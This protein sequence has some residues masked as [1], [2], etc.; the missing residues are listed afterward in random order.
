[1]TRAPTGGASETRAESVVASPLFAFAYIGLMAASVLY[2]YFRIVSLPWFTMHVAYI[3]IIGMACVW[4]FVT[5]R[6]SRLKN[7]FLAIAIY[8]VPYIVMLIQSL[9]IWIFEMDA[10]S[11]IKRGGGTIAYQLL[12]ITTVAAAY[13]LFGRRAILYTFLGMAAGNALL[14][15]SAIRTIGMG[16]F[17]SQLF[18]FFRSFG[19]ED[20]AA[21]KALEVHDL[22]FA[23]GIFVLYFWLF[24]KRGPLKWAGLLASVVFFLLG[25]KRIAIP[26]LLLAGL[27]VIRTRRCA[28]DRAI[29]RTRYF[30]VGLV[31]AS[32]LYLVLIRSGGY[33]ELMDRFGIDTM[34]RK[35]L[36]LFIEGYYT[37][38]PLYIGRGIGFITRMMQD[39]IESGQAVLNA[40]MSIH[41]DILARYIELGF[42][43]FLFWAVYLFYLTPRFIGKRWSTEAMMMSFS[44]LIYCFLTYLTDNTAGYYHINYCLRLFPLALAGCARPGSGDAARRS[45]V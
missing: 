41:N 33:I 20:T 1:M 34:G 27:Y 23:F 19:G 7:A 45:E 18:A 16:D 15:F 17:V 42:F 44:A 43:G 28:R 36:L 30:G 26:G 2:P 13:V 21:S 6:F 3:V 31:V 37:L 38:S 10:M 5:G 32:Y 35:Q 25:W 40:A 11:L 29:R 4:V 12:G 22:T 24:E 39:F 14:I 8:C 9:L